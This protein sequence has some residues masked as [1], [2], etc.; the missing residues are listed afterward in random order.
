MLFMDLG[1]S[2]K[3]LKPS[4]ATHTQKVVLKKKKMGKFTFLLPTIVLGL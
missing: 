1:V 4:R 2:L 3:I